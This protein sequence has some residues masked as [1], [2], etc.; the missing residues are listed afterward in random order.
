[1]EISQEL[2][3]LPNLDPYQGTPK[4]YSIFTIT[5]LAQIIVYIVLDLWMLIKPHQIRE[6]QVPKQ[7]KKKVPSQSV[8]AIYVWRREQ[9]QKRHAYETIVE[10]QHPRKGKSITFHEDSRN[11]RNQDGFPITPAE[12]YE[13]EG[14]RKIYHIPRPV[15]QIG[16]KGGN[17]YATLTLIIIFVCMVRMINVQRKQTIHYDYIEEIA[18]I[19]NMYESWP[20]CM[21]KGKL[22]SILLLLSNLYQ[23][24]MLQTVLIHEA[25]AIYLAL[26]GQ[27]ESFAEEQSLIISMLLVSSRM[28]CHE[29]STVLMC[30]ATHWLTKNVGI[31]KMIFNPLYALTTPQWLPYTTLAVAIV[32]FVPYFYN[33]LTDNSPVDLSTSNSQTIGYVQWMR[34]RMTYVFY[35]VLF[36]TTAIITGITL[37]D[38][39]KAV[40]ALSFTKCYDC[41]FT[42]TICIT[43]MII[44]SYKSTTEGADNELHL[45]AITDIATQTSKIGYH[46]GGGFYAG[47][48]THNPNTRIVPS[49]IYGLFTKPTFGIA[50][51]QGLAYAGKNGKLTTATHVINGY[52]CRLGNEMISITEH[53]PSQDI[54]RQEG[55]GHEPHSD[56]D[57]V[58]SSFVIRGSTIV[59]QN[60]QLREHSNVNA[61]V[62]D[63]QTHYKHGNSGAPVFRG[64]KFVATITQGSPWGI[65]N[66]SY[67]CTQSVPEEAS[68]ITED[69][70]EKI[71]NE[72]RKVYVLHCGAGKTRK[73]IPNEV[74]K[75]KGKKD[76]VVTVP[77]RIVAAE[78][79]DLPEFQDFSCDVNITPKVT[80]VGGNN[81]LCTH[82]TAIKR[83]LNHVN[84]ETIEEYAK[85]THYIVDEAHF[86][87]ATTIVL[88]E[89]L[90]HYNFT[91]TFYTATWRGHTAYKTNFP[92]NDASFSTKRLKD[93]L[94]EHLSDKVII[95]TTGIGHNREIKKKISSL[96]PSHKIFSLSRDEMKLNKSL[97]ETIKNYQE[98]CV[99]LSTAV[100]EVG[101][102]LNVDVVIDFLRTPKMMAITGHD[103]KM[104]FKVMTTPITKAAKVQRRGRV[105]RNKPGTYYY[106]SDVIVNDALYTSHSAALCIANS[107]LRAHQIIPTFPE[108]TGYMDLTKVEALHLLDSE[109]VTTI[110][111]YISNTLN[112]AISNE[113]DDEAPIPKQW[114]AQESQT[115]KEEEKK[116]DDEQAKKD[117]QFFKSKFKTNAHKICRRIGIT[118]HC[119]V[120]M[121]ITFF[122]F[123]LCACQEDIPFLMDEIEAK[124][125][126]VETF[127]KM[128]TSKY[129]AEF[130]D[131]TNRVIRDIKTSYLYALVYLPYILVNQAYKEE[132]HLILFTAIVIL[133][134]IAILVVLV[135]V[136]ILGA[137]I[138]KITDSRLATLAI[139]LSALVSISVALD[140][141]NLWRV[142]P[143]ISTVI[144]VSMIIMIAFI[145]NTIKNMGLL[146]SDYLI[147]SGSLTVIMPSIT[148][149]LFTTYF[150]TT[151]NRIGHSPI[152]TIS[153]GWT[154]G[155]IIMQF[156]NQ[157]HY[158][159]FIASYVVGKDYVLPPSMNVNASSIVRLTGSF[160]RLW[161]MSQESSFDRVSQTL[162]MIVVGSMFGI[163]QSGIPNDI[164]EI[165]RQEKAAPPQAERVR[166]IINAMSKNMVQS[167]SLFGSVGCIIGV[168]WANNNID[169]AICVIGAVCGLT[170]SQ[171]MIANQ[172]THRLISYGCTGSIEL[173]FFQLASG[174]LTDQV[175]QNI[176]YLDSEYEFVHKKIA[177]TFRQVATANKE[178]WDAFR[179]SGVHELDQESK[180]K[181]ASRSVLKWLPMRT[182]LENRPNLRILEIGC[183]KGSWLQSI[184]TDKFITYDKYVAYN[185][186]IKVEDHSNLDLRV[187]SQTDSRFELRLKNVH[188]DYDKLLNEHYDVVLG[189]AGSS[190]VTLKKREEDSRR[191]HILVESLRRKNPETLFFYKNLV[192]Y[193]LAEGNVHYYR[194]PA[195]RNSSFEVYCTNL[196]TPTTSTYDNTTLGV[197]YQKMLEKLHGKRKNPILTR[198]IY[199]YEEPCGPRNNLLEPINHKKQLRDWE[200]RNTREI[201]VEDLQMDYR[202]V[203]EVGWVTTNPK[204]D[205][206]DLY[207]RVI[208]KFTNPLLSLIPKLRD[209]HL[210]DVGTDGG[211]S[212]FKKK[213]D[214][215]PVENHRHWNN[216]SEAFKQIGGRIRRSGI[217]IERVQTE[218]AAKNIQMK[219]GKQ[220]GET[221]QINP[222]FLQ[223]IDDMYETLCKAPEEVPYSVVETMPKREKK[224]AKDGKTS[225]SR[226]ISFFPLKFRV[227]EQVVLGRFVD[228]AVRRDVVPESVGHVIP[229]SYFQKMFDELQVSNIDEPK[230]I[231]DDI[232]GWDTR[233]ARRMLE[234]ES[235]FLEELTDDPVHKKAIHNLYR[236]YADHI[237]T[238]KRNINGKTT[239]RF[240]N[241][242]K[243]R[244]SGVVT[245]YSMNTFTNIALTRAHIAD[246]LKVSMTEVEAMIENKDI[247]MLIS[248]DDKVVLANKNIIKVLANSIDF[249]AETGFYRKDVEGNAPSQIYDMEQVPFCSHTPV[250]IEVCRRRK[251][252]ADR[253][254]DEI[255]G[256]AR[257]SVGAFSDQSGLAE[258]AHAKA[259][260]NTLSQYL[261]RRDIRLLVSELHKVL[262]ANL[263]P[264]AKTSKPKVL[265][266]TWLE[267]MD[268]LE[269]WKKIYEN[270]E[271]RSVADIGFTTQ[272]YDQKM[273]SPIHTEGRRAWKNNMVKM[274]DTRRKLIL[275]LMPEAKF[276]DYSEIFPDREEKMKNQVVPCVALTIYDKLK[277][278]DITNIFLTDSIHA[279]GI[280]I[281]ESIG[282]NVTKA[283]YAQVTIHSISKGYTQEEIDDV[284][285]IAQKHNHIGIMYVSTTI[286][287][288]KNQL[289]I[290][291]EVSLI[292]P[293]IHVYLQDVLKE[294]HMRGYFPIS[295]A[296]SQKVAEIISDDMIGDE[297]FTESFSGDGRIG[298]SMLEKGISVQDLVDIHPL[299]RCVIR[300]DCL[301]SEIMTNCAVANPPWDRRDGYSPIKDYIRRWILSDKCNKL[302]MVGPTGTE[303]R[304]AVTSVKGDI[305][306]ESIGAFKH[307]T[308]AYKITHQVPD[309]VMTLAVWRFEKRK[310][311]YFTNLIDEMFGKHSPNIFKHRF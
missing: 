305:L 121:I 41:V 290:R 10:D 133:S 68:V 175:Q 129:M 309:M 141:Y 206:G 229:T 167:E 35:A 76:V 249:W 85:N 3:Y 46:I 271:I 219:K 228:E 89:L 156:K 214:T 224:K 30:L 243:G 251:V 28:R 69:I 226:L 36:V 81:R 157:F 260:V 107:F 93:I 29:M 302:Y 180:M 261:F 143:T 166:S 179:H 50:L 145:V 296:N 242:R 253:P 274:R 178:K 52:T 96:N 190:G 186:P 234:E 134:T 140:T 34:E 21:T 209:Y 205:S 139:P 45:I 12:F 198:D 286:M 293:E 160:I 174:I 264:E 196:P 256:K 147:A 20:K 270:D 199:D 203:S 87:A 5:L 116:S 204:N 292:E 6:K 148:K 258:L 60:E 188:D 272:K 2:R 110:D 241:Q 14:R 122:M 218:E 192:P 62:L 132:A 124:I 225:S 57:G 97:L 262:P 25:Y 154:V 247:I 123:S 67:V 232:A 37:Y 297:I 24:H 164:L 187:H 151:I 294:E 104:S 65:L 72:G 184:I 254:L 86:D 144:I 162:F 238:I 61:M 43:S 280:E 63:T 99:I 71:E 101:A 216:I 301:S 51:L 168:F 299:D 39:L 215:P 227:L 149:E 9:I 191:M 248:G 111:H 127:E 8:W 197:M 55:A 83:I 38:L 200:I 90:A 193:V 265:A 137:I 119:I 26:T 146:K 56:K 235:K 42:L 17:F 267:E 275:D 208:Q 74:R 246:A 130:A 207:N 125:K 311:P 23:P 233:I 47:I 288:F 259:I 281:F 100:S 158:N 95:Y 54:S 18:N 266:K 7:R 269:A 298:K 278:L 181:W 75:Q 189:D 112:I 106:A 48:S 66:Q 19:G 152:F 118:R 300:G 59:R 310:N 279:D 273:G 4:V 163:L 22:P 277:Q 282:I 153:V 276:E 79:I 113:G 77:T 131:T 84:K 173:I 236:L 53:Y 82:P 202:S 31:A 210:T 222:L 114:S 155:S 11:F 185:L 92:V 244:L 150:S 94:E 58:F 40:L 295:V 182:Y 70:D 120:F 217:T 44:C 223:E 126:P 138:R 220:Y 170:S 115:E 102:N 16:K 303:F 245:T 268:I 289:N 73:Y 213:V 183:G 91:A 304:E 128:M 27:T 103:G 285:R 231:A 240:L 49:T 159:N 13:H 165:A 195:T 1:M 212:M 172:E 64:N 169:K 32:C 109:D 283:A 142:Y 221:W 33:L 263:M 211:Y 291:E 108:A 306:C 171:A 80:R 237:I 15:S 177:N 201:Q 287:G 194:S 284:Y 257:L 252:V 308:R 135:I 176:S 98:P 307:H 239:M 136:S 230:C 250:V 78:I 117:Y 88:L 255:I 161:I 105:G